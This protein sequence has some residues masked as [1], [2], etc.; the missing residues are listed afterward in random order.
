[1]TISACFLV[2]V[3]LMCPVVLFS[4]QTL[5][6]DIQRY[7]LALVHNTKVGSVADIVYPSGSGHCLDA[8]H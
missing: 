1:M 8:D 3:F 5:T 4:V 7:A 2:I 6:S